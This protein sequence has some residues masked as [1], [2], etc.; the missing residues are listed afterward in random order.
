MRSWTFAGALNAFARAW[1][2]PLVAAMLTLVVY[3]LRVG[4]SR[5]GFAA[6]TSNY[7]NYLAQAFLGGQTNLIERP[8]LALDLVFFHGKIYLYW[9]PFPALVMMPFVSLFGVDVN[10][11]VITAGLGAISVAALASF[12]C[13][14]DRAGI[15]PLEVERRG[16]LVL[17]TA[18][19]SVLLILSTV[20]GVWYTAQVVGFGLVLLGLN[21]GIAMRGRAG[22][23]WAGFWLACAMATRLS[24][25]F[26]G[27]WLAWYLFKRDFRGEGAWF[28][29]A[30][31]ALLPPVVTLALLGWYNAARFGSPLDMGL[32]YHNFGDTFRADYER[33]GIFSLHYL[34]IN[35]YY[36][37][38]AY[39]IFGPDKWKGSGIFWLTPLYLG[40]LTA[41]VTARRHALTW[42]LVATCA[43]IYIPIGV[44]MGTGYFTFG[45]RYLLDFTPTLLV[46]V[47]MGL[48]RWPMWTMWAAT[49]IGLAT[50]TYGS[51]AMRGQ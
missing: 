21:A 27:L 28:R 17:T 2:N 14:L 35:V 15:A 26:N 37:F 42:W 45:P 24:L 44:L 7:F 38:I 20:A 29:L 47:A 3:L 32:A 33:Y 11:A 22:Y 12:L 19:G 48:R 43:L 16:L 6:T 5:T 18:F 13:T 36:Q 46:L 49:G 39:S 10:D 9:P 4:I 31:I 30:A 51:L 40:A 50:Y 8:R 1:S 41:L 25:V 34:P 23:F